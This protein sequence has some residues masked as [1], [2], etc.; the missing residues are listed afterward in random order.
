[1]KSGNLNFLEPSG[2]LQA[3]NG[4]A[5]PFL[6][7]IYQITLHHSPDGD[8]CTHCC[9][10]SNLILYTSVSA[11]LTQILGQFLQAFLFIQTGNTEQTAT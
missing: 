1:M 5:L 7:F 4:T 9:D 11:K 10:N 8:H 2:P 6:S 3:C